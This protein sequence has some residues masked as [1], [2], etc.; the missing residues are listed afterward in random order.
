MGAAAAGFLPLDLLKLRLSPMV[1]L[2]L[3]MVW[4]MGKSEAG[5]PVSRILSCRIHHHDELYLGALA[6]L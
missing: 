3:L 5:S 2:L 4:P 1:A 6:V